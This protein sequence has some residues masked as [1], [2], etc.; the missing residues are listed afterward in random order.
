VCA[1]LVS[2]IHW[3]CCHHTGAHRKEIDVKD[4]WEVVVRVLRQALQDPRYKR[5][6]IARA[7]FQKRL[8]ALLLNTKSAAA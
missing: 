3:G 8:I 4:D 6:A 5:N 2:S 7:L 1:H